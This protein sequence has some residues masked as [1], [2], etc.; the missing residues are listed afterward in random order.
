MRSA[1]R[2]KGALSNGPCVTDLQRVEEQLTQILTRLV[3]LQIH[4]G[5]AP[6]L[7]ART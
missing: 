4:P 7:P 2:L 6:M 3:Y 5:A 1:R